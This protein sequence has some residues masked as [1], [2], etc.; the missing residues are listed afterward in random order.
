MNTSYK[1]IIL[2]SI[3]LLSMYLLYQFSRTK[4]NFSNL[5]IPTFESNQKISNDGHLCDAEL[6]NIMIG[7]DGKNLSEFCRRFP[8]KIDKLC[9]SFI[10]EAVEINNTNLAKKTTEDLKILKKF[11]K[12]YEKLELKTGFGEPVRTMD[13]MEDECLALTKQDELCNIVSI[14]NVR[15]DEMGKCYMFGNI[16]KTV[17]HES[18]TSYKKVYIISYSIKFNININD[19]TD[20]DRIIFQH[21]NSEDKCFPCIK[22]IANTNNIEF[23]AQSQDCENST[24]DGNSNKDKLVMQNVDLKKWINICFTVKGKDVK[25]FLDGNLYT[26]IEMEK[27]PYWPIEKQDATIVPSWSRAS[28]YSLSKFCWI[29]VTL[30]QDIIQTLSSV[31]ISKQNA[32]S[33]PNQSNVDVPPTIQLQN[34]WEEYIKETKNGRVWS[35]IQLKKKTNIVFISGMVHKGTIV[36][37]NSIIGV[38]PEG[39]RPDTDRCPIKC[40][41]PGGTV[42]I[43][44]KANGNLEIKVA[45]ESVDESEFRSNHRY[46]PGDAN[47]DGNKFISLSNIR[48][49]ITSG[50]NKIKGTNNLSYEKL[51][52]LIFFTGTLECIERAYLP[53]NTIP[54][55]PRTNIL[56][57]TKSQY[58]ALSISP[59]GML[60]VWLETVKSCLGC[61]DKNQDNC[62]NKFCLDG[63]CFAKYSGEEIKLESGFSAL[64]RFNK[65]DL[66]LDNNIVK[67][68]GLIKIGYQSNKDFQSLDKAIGCFV[69]DMESLDIN[70]TL[71]DCAKKAR[72]SGYPFFGIGE[73]NYC[74][75]GNYYGSK[76]VADNC[77]SI[78]LRD[79]ESQF[80]CGSSDSVSVFSSDTTPYLISL[81]PRQYRPS[82]TLIFACE[83]IAKTVLKIYS[84]YVVIFNTGHMFL[85][86]THNL[87][88][89]D[90]EGESFIISIDNI[91]YA[92]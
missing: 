89:E 67:M 29:P 32:N 43:F 5:N 83:T 27:Y 84:S 7:N 86:G 63:Q 72:D 58:N 24:C 6:D 57:N 12:E 66:I 3:V 77:G 81:I 91:C 56:I 68:S 36:N 69:N 62:D 13:L 85:L 14:G 61:S 33:N 55:V 48:Y 8:D 41:T 46:I 19:V 1:L 30:N 82:S 37:G 78:C 53:P 31:E 18:R 11:A 10:D 35:G 39:Y 92:K 15:G 22:I 26:E 87:K 70:T 52:G 25:A 49:P 76:G 20:Y 21:G 38:I 4:E 54:E 65:P 9:N 34:G 50:I 59:G 90:L 44:V 40:L 51:G 64:P 2:I 16:G 75:G 79:D 42:N 17:E 47:V 60:N 23:F 80:P 88:K 28:K 71:E 73:N 74:F 45:D